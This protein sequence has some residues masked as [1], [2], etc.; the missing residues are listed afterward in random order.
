MNAKRY[1]NTLTLLPNPISRTLQVS[2]CLTDSHLQF[3]QYHH[4]ELLQRLWVLREQDQGFLLWYPACAVFKI[5]HTVYWNQDWVEKR[6][7]CHK[8]M[9]ADNITSSYIDRMDISFVIILLFASFIICSVV[10][11]TQSILL[12]LLLIHYNYSYRNKG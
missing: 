10:A 1:P 11:F 6:S 9:F 12:L 8:I 2:L 5:L 3:L 7:R 4:S